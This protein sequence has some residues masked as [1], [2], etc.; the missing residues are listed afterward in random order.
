MGIYFM[1]NN[2]RP[3]RLATYNIHG[4]WGMDK[5][6]DLNRIA[7]VIKN[8]QV[9]FIAVNEIDCNCGRSE[10]A[11]QPAV[12]AELLQMNHHFAPALEMRSERFPEQGSEV[13][14]YGVAF[15]TPH[16]VS[17][18]RQF[19]LPGLPE[20]EPRTAVIARVDA[21][22]MSFYAVVTHFCWE[23]K[24]EQF[25]VASVEAINAEVAQVRRQHPDEPV[26]L[27]GDL[28]AEP[29]SAPI[30]ELRKN[31]VIA[32]EGNFQATHPSDAPREIIDYI[33]FARQSTLRWKKVEIIPELVASD[34]R[35]LLAELE[36]M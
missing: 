1:E 6:L 28:N 3:L 21:P 24:Y 7:S 22:Q 5:V 4:G 30:E 15:Y 33:M 2:Y 11:D 31:Y 27:L 13:G 34:H 18:I 16:Q 9:D 20:M 23:P 19:M 8:M 25:R 36:W 17:E 26:F 12:L 35:P 29:Y 10:F 14:L 32:N